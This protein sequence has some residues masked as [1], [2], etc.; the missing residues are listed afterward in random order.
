MIILNM[1]VHHAA[2]CIIINVI[3]YYI[4]VFR[5]SNRNPIR[6]WRLRSIRRHSQTVGVARRLR[7][8]ASLITRHSLS[9]P[10]SLLIHI[11]MY[12]YVFMCIYT[13]IN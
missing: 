4:V 9:P 6:V 2:S 3:C 12:V 8:G 13:R 10:L 11:C 7:R 5:G 1:A